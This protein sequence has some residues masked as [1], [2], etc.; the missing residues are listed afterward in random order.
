V[1]LSPASIKF[2]K[3]TEIP[4]PLSSKFHVPQKTVVPNNE[5]LTQTQQ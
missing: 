3:N 2:S 5:A 1:L 4:H